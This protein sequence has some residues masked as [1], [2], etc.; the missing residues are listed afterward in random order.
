MC[1]KVDF[2]HHPITNG[3]VRP[4][5]AGYDILVYKVLKMRVT[6]YATPYQNYPVSMGKPIVAQSLDAVRV[7]KYYND[8]SDRFT[9]NEG[10]HA[11]VSEAG[12]DYERSGWCM[13]DL[14]VVP[15]VIPK[16]TKFFFG[17]GFDGNPYADIVAKKLII[18]RN[19]EDLLKGRTRVNADL[20]K[21]R[22]A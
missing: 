18:Y 1:L 16:G 2:K 20:T 3:K 6:G 10:V 14:V 15:A 9:V 7:E 13:Y 4:L 11:F 12:A 17:Y 21:H 19:M 5:I 8:D 22:S